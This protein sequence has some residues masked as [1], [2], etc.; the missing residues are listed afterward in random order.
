VK[1]FDQLESHPFR[2]VLLLRLILW[3]NPPLSYALAFMTMPARIYIAACA[4]ALLPIVAGAMIA[5][6]WF[7]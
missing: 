5:T 6:G 4:V 1:I 3:F 7:I 2:S